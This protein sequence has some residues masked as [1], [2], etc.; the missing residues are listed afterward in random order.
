VLELSRPLVLERPWAEVLE[1]LRHELAHQY[2]DEVLGVRDEPP[3][4]PTFQRVCRERAIDARA[5]GLPSAPPEE[6]RS[7]RLVE[8]VRR[9]FALAAS[10]NQHEAELA[11]QRAQELMLRHQLSLETGEQH[12]VFRHVGRPKRRKSRAEGLI[13]A[14]LAD[15]FFVEVIWVYVYAPYTGHIERVLEVC[16]TE[17]NVSMADYVHDFLLRTA[18]ELWTQARASHP[19]LGPGDRSAYLAGVIAGFRQK[20][21]QARRNHQSTGLIYLGDP[22]LQTYYRRRHPQVRTRSARPSPRWAVQA[23]GRAHGENVV[24]HRPL[25]QDPSAAGPRLLGD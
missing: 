10:D 15:H 20:L 9:L 7:A 3:H 13:A 8:R 4:G 18:E 25:E 23:L 6:P 21:E 19:N 14:L 11:M 5:A 2:V 1:V 17:G 12:Y 22:A 16:G 24:L